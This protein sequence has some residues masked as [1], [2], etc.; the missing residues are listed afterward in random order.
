MRG[1]YGGWTTYMTRIELGRLSKP[2]R[3]G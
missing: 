2:I 1:A 3:V